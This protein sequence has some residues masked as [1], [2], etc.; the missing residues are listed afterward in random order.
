MLQYEYKVTLF[1]CTSNELS[2]Q[3]LVELGLTKIIRIFLISFTC[4]DPVE[5]V[6]LF[7][8]IDLIFEKLFI[9]FIYEDVSY[10]CNG[11]QVTF[12]K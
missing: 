5:K 10:I 2:P 8:T 1:L 7:K 6:V 12:I 11:G 3:T 4:Q 9:L